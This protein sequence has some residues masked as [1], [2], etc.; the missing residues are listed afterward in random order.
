MANKKYRTNV[1]QRRVEKPVNQGFVAAN[2]SMKGPDGGIPIESY[3]YLTG[4][5][6]S[7]VQIKQV[8]IEGRE[9][10]NK[11]LEVKVN[12]SEAIGDEVRE[13]PNLLKC[14]LGDC[15]VELQ[16]KVQDLV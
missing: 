6:K 14:V 5:F 3:R 11:K 15:D 12:N 9:V 1:T 7:Y 10:T 8:N 4:D 16:S 2:P 13:S